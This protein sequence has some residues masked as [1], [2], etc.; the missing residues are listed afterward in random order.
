[1]FQLHPIVLGGLLYVSS[2]YLYRAAVQLSN[3]DLIT[4][5]PCL[6]RLPLSVSPHLF[7]W[8]AGW[9]TYVSTQLNQSL[10]SVLTKLMEKLF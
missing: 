7:S 10:A 1:M 4:S 9:Y 3:S 6:S 2:R 5:T 8:K